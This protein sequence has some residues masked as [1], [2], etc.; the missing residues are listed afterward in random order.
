[1]ITNN[2]F[3]AAAR[4]SFNRFMQRARSG[5]AKR[6]STIG[7]HFPAGTRFTGTTHAD[8]HPVHDMQIKRLCYLN[9]SRYGHYLEVRTSRVRQAEA[10]VRLPGFPLL[11]KALGDDAPRNA[12]DGKPGLCV[13]TPDG[14]PTYLKCAMESSNE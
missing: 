4:L 8:A 2:L 3:A 11:L 1:M 6:R 7:I 10:N 13:F 9:F 5:D 12:V 14:P